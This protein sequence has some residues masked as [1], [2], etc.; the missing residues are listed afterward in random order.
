MA[1]GGVFSYDESVGSS[2][3]DDIGAVANGIEASLND[4]GNFVARVKSNWQG[5]EQEIYAGIQ[6][7][8][9]NA[10]ATV[11]E[12]LT[13]VKG[14]LGQT[15]SSVQEMRGQVRGALQG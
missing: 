6:T 7:Q 4:L 8:W 5:D 2:A 13:S 9:D 1:A 3:T 12:I 11:K 14:A 15:T 10:A